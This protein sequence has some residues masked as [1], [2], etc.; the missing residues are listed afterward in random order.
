MLFINQALQMAFLTNPFTT[1]EVFFLKV[2]IFT[3]RVF[4]KAQKTVMYCIMIFF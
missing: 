1:E 2:Y 4:Q 3:L